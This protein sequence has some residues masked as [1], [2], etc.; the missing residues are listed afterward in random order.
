MKRSLIAAFCFLFFVGS[1]SA[2]RCKYEVNQEDGI[3]GDVIRTV[4][5][6][7]TGPIA[8]VS[9]Y[10]YFY[11]VRS[12]S[13]FKFRVEVA[14]FG[15]FSHSIPEGSELAMRLSDG[16]VIR[17]TSTKV[18]EPTEI[19]EYSTVLT[20]Y[21]IEYQTTEEDMRKITKAGIAF[22]RATDFKN[23]FSDQKIPPAVTEQSKFNANC[24]F[25]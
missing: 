9:P 1:V 21:D 3:T 13:D 20:G 17:M 7:I 18:S 12:G 14:D 5:N 24:I 25:N 4:K 22:I 11:Y 8:G 16:E 6:R 15:E 19:K 23:S 10:Y 2:Q